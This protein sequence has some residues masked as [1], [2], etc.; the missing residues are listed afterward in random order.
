MSRPKDNTLSK[1][2]NC[3]HRIVSNIFR[4][5]FLKS[6]LPEKGKSDYEIE[7]E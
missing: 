6:K 3:T 1:T 5:E 2:K 7:V 4:E